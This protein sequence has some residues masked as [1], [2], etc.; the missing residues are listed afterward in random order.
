VVGLNSDGSV[1]RI[2]GHRRP[3][4]PASQRAEVLAALACVDFVTLFEETD[5]LRLIQVLEPD[6]LVKGGDWPENRIIG[7]DA[8]KQRGGR[9]VRVP[10]V[11][12]LG[13]SSIIERI[14]QRYRP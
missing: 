2:K 9:V 7:A 14:L 11:E 3:I 12:G 4:V 8:V 6:V 1:R 5:P 13:T 10:L